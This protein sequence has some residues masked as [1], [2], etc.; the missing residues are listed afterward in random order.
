MGSCRIG[1]PEITLAL[2]NTALTF[3]DLF[4]RE[5]SFQS[6]Q[7]ARMDHLRSA[8][9]PIGERVTKAM[10]EF[11]KKCQEEKDDLDASL[12]ALPSFL[13]KLDLIRHEDLPRHEK[14]FKDRLNDTIAKEMGVFNSELLQEGKNI[15]NKIEEL[16]EALRELPYNEGTFMRLDMRH[17]KNAEVSEF[18]SSLR[19]CLDDTFDNTADANEARFLRMEKLI[20][21]LSEDTTWR[22]RSSTCAS[23]TI[24][25]L[26]KLR[27]KLETSEAITKIAVG[28]PVAKKLV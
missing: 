11:L 13:A 7:G 10:G 22:D 5:R 6:E 8:I 21:R 17:V 19:S 1:F 12:A 25:V 16:N 24:L 3:E 9:E 4:E 18:K 27:S 23:G 28:S 26:A 20:S 14:R 15:Q 2:G